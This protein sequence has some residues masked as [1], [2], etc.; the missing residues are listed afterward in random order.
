MPIEINPQAPTERTVGLLAD[1]ATRF[2]WERNFP[3]NGLMVYNYGCNGLKRGTIQVCF[4]EDD[5][6]VDAPGNPSFAR[7]GAFYVTANHTC[8]NLSVD[9]VANW[10][11]GRIDDVWD[12]WF[13]E[14]LAAELE[15]GGFASDVATSESDPTPVDS[16]TLANSATVISAVPGDVAVAIAAVER[17]L[18]DRLHGARGL[19]HL[20]VEV[21]AL[22]GDAVQFRDGQWETRSG[23]RVVADAGYVGAA[24][25]DES[26]SSGVRWIYGSGPIGYTVG[27]LDD[28]PPQVDTR[29]NQGTARSV[30]HAIF[31]FEPCTVVAAAA[32]LPDAIGS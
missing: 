5:V 26:E 28:L 30:A 22:A 27:P 2:D 7:F 12:P 14:Q 6:L 8:S 24:P 29:R 23:H 16:P 21:L 20:P 4:D 32:E 17:G 10:L 15:V 31:A 18:A 11:Q 19:V 13:S 9:D 25:S 1:L 3:S